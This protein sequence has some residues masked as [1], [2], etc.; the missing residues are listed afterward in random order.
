VAF[1]NSLTDF[2]SPRASSGSFC[3][4]KR[5]SA[6]TRMTI[7][8]W[9]PSPNMETLQGHASVVGAAGTG[10][11]GG[12]TA[13]P[14]QGAAPERSREGAAL[15]AGRDAG[16]SGREGPREARRRRRRAQPLHEG[17]YRDG[18]EER[19]RLAPV[20]PPQ[21]EHQ[22]VRVPAVVRARELEGV[23]GGH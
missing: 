8:S 20:R 2:P 17:R 23:R 3:A 5:N 10:A 1:L 15:A 18:R 13:R 9:L 4:P 21:G 14:G 12:S 22:V 16:P 6:I 19:S 11:G 7:S